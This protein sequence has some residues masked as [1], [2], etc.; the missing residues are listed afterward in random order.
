MVKLVN[1]PDIPMQREKL[2][3]LGKKQLVRKLIKSKLYNL[4][5]MIKELF[6]D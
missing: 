6:L 1:P 5:I 2:Y 3:K 4:S